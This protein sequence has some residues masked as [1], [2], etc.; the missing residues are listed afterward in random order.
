MHFSCFMNHLMY[1]LRV[2]HPRNASN[3]FFHIL[4]N[5][6][7]FTQCH[8]SI[9]SFRMISV[10]SSP[11]FRIIHVVCPL[12][13]QRA[14]TKEPV[15]RPIVASWTYPWCYEKRQ[16]DKVAF[17]LGA[18]YVPSNSAKIETRPIASHCTP[19]PAG[20]TPSILHND[21]LRSLVHLTTVCR[22]AHK[23]KHKPALPGK[24]IYGTSQHR[25]GIHSPNTGWPVGPFNMSHAPRPKQVASAPVAK[26]ESTFLREWLFIHGTPKDTLPR[27]FGPHVFYAYS[28]ME[29]AGEVLTLYLRLAP[30]EKMFN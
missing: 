7:C 25:T 18:K 30:I 24:S 9:F 11:G 22:T 19:C 3:S 12:H 5:L 2:S 8:P 21:V 16:Y 23:H 17:V 10:S 14:P 4:L 1:L 13:P 6:D 15:C 29:V 26:T 27:V 20:A 28:C